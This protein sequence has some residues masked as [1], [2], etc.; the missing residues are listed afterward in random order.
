MS[1]DYAELRRIEIMHQH[2][3]AAQALNQ[4]QSHYGYVQRQQSPEERRTGHAV[5][6]SFLAI[7]WLAALVFVLAHGFER[8][9]FPAL[10]Y[11]IPLIIGILVAAL[12][13]LI[14]TRFKFSWMALSLAAATYAAF[15]L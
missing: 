13:V 8:H 5:S 6:A 11:G 9:Q 4:P 10:P 3:A 14:P 7:P 1:D 2:S 12:G 15:N